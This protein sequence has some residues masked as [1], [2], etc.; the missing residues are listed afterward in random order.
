MQIMEEN[1]KSINEKILLNKKKN[2]HFRKIESVKNQIK[3]SDYA[4]NRKR[5]TNMRNHYIT[6]KLQKYE[7]I[8]QIGGGKKMD[9]NMFLKLKDKLETQMVIEAQNMMRTFQSLTQ[10]EKK[11]GHHTEYTHY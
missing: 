6:E 11:K 8:A 9:H 5:I 10:K 2:Q 3:K 1:F 4:E 7:V